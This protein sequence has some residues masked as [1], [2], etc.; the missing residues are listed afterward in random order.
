MECLLS[1]GQEYFV[2]HSAIKKEHNDQNT[3]NIMSPVDLCEC[4]TWSLI[5]RE[6]R[7]G[8]GFENRVLR[9]IFGV[10]EETS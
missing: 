2:F 9:K 4:E 10:D 6:E 3:E 8:N 5:L 7:Q 1:F